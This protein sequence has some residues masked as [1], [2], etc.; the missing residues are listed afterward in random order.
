MLPLLMFFLTKSKLENIFF[1]EPC[2]NRAL[3]LPKTLLL[4][5]AVRVNVILIDT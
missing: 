4:T 5:T 3:R 2:A 1:V